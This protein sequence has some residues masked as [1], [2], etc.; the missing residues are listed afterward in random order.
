MESFNNLDM[1]KL[2]KLTDGIPKVKDPWGILC[3]I[4]NIIWPGCG[5]I[6]SACE[7]VGGKCDWTQVIIGLLQSFTVFL[8]FLGW[9]WSIWWGVLI[10]QKA[11]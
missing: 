3:L 4:F 1:D 8:F 5:T 10:Y 6:C 7:S 11:K 2:K 9:I